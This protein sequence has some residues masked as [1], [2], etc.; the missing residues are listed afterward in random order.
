MLLDPLLDFA[1]MRRALV[2]TLALALSAPPL[3]VFL[4][5]RRLALIGDALGHAI[6]P[7]VAVG[8]ALF[9]LSLAAMSAG[10]MFAG[11]A[12]MLASGALSRT[13]ALAEDASLAG[14]YLIALALGVAIV[15]LS[16]AQVD[17]LQ[18]LF[19][20]VLG[21]D[22]DALLLMATT[23]TLT[24]V[25]LAI[26]WRPLVI[27]TFDSGFLRAKGGRGAAWHLGFLVLVVLNLVA[28][29]QALGT[30]M[31]VGLMM[32]P[33][34]AA[35]FVS[36]TLGGRVV[37][38]CLIAMAAVFTGL[39]VSFHADVPAGPAVVLTAAVLWLAVMVA[40]PEGSLLARTLRRPHLAG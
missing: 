18:L 13:G 25:S 32:V 4:I 37:S 2:G 26:M 16:S 33:A 17:V 12:V 36:A 38:A 20:S 22:D 31:A 6:L 34:L 11:L 23:A 14:L 5:Q 28:A 24:L 40:G 3:G 9:G 29:F 10:G 27:E 21:V 39:L 30:L 1:F 19:G 35:R 7:G 15:S 8:A